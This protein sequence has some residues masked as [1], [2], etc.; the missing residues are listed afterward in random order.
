MAPLLL[1]LPNWLGDL[2]LAWPVIDAAA[3]SGPLLLVGP[4]SFEPIL[5]ARYPDARYLAWSRSRRYALAGAIR[6]E[7][8]RA[9]LLLTES[10]SSALLVALAGVPERIG[11]AGEGRGL[12]LT[13]RV[14]REAPPRAAPRTAE[15]KTLAAAAGLSARGDPRL[16]A[17]EAER[18]AAAELLHGKVPP[19]VPALP[20]GTAALAYVIVAPGAAYGPAKQWGGDRFGRAAAAAAVPR[21]EIVITVGSSADG[22]AASEVVAA[23]QAAG[24]DALDLT[25]ATD[26][27]SLVGLV[28]GAAL[29]LSNDSGVMHL[30]AALGRPTVALFGST[31]PLWTSAS[32]PHVANL[33]AAYPCSPC[34]RRTCPIGYGCLRALDA[35]RA[36]RA[37]EA[38][39][40]RTV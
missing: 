13:R 3:R 30:A 12:L 16:A 17:T 10:L 37:A 14:V 26:L 7:R 11:Y 5:R 39:R 4:R 34:Y 9:A 38:V 23:A 2:V 36:I 35:D 22:N 40:S 29:V 28:A 27:P 8:P 33:Y 19:P 24:A 1:R 32:A 31:S 18:R 20:D 6:R 15:Y 21:R 25:G